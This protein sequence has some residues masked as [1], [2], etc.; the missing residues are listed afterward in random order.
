ML[1]SIVMGRLVSFLGKMVF[2]E[3]VS[4]CAHWFGFANIIA[5]LFF[6]GFVVVV[7]VVV[8]VVAAIVFVIVHVIVLFF[9]LLL[10]LPVVVL[11]I[12]L[13]V[14]AVGSGLSLLRLAFLLSICWI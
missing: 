14:V 1:F 13:L 4:P 2:I 8:A 6:G 9:L 11:F 12:L 3:H 5:V 7:V 10:L